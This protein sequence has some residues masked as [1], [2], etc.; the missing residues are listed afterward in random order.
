MAARKKMDLLAAIE[1]IVDKAKGTGLSAEFFRKADRYIR[2]VS[3]VMELTKEQSVMLALFVDNSCDTDI[4]ISSFGEYLGCRTSRLLR[5]MNDIDVLEKRELIRGRHSHDEVT[6]R[7]PVEL[8]EALKRN[9]KY[10]PKDYTGLTCVELFGELANIFDMR[11]NK[12]LRYGDMVKKIDD[13]FCCNSNLEYVQKVKSYGFSERTRMLLILFSHLFVNNSDDNVGWHD[14]EF[15]HDGR[16][17]WI[18]V[19]NRLSSGN[20]PLLE[21]NI[22]ENN[23]DGG[24]GDR[25]SFRMT[26]KAKNELF[27]ELNLTSMNKRSK[28]GDIV[29]YENIVPKA[30]FYNEKNKAQVEELA[31]LLDD[32]KYNQIRS[33]MKDTGFRCAFTCLLY[34]APGTGKTETALQLARQTGRDIM[35][36]NISQIKSMWVGE[37]EKNIK[38]VFDNYRAMVNDSQTTPILLFNEADAIIGKRQEGTL[39]SVDKMEN[40]IQNIILQEMEMLDGI[41]IATTNLAQNM[42]KAFE[43]RFLYKIKFDKPTVEARTSMWREMIPVLNEE[44]SRILAGKFDFSGGQIENIARHYTIGKILHGDSEDVVNTLSTYCESEKLES[45]DKLRIGFW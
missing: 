28:R 36:V 9:E 29:R 41:L 20:H 32:E 2:Y 8:I 5:Y 31:S 27:G 10:V 1:Q 26:N 17:M 12:E 30:L 13:L 23:N 38:Q 7:V 33:R 24:F 34:G 40:S 22:I 16:A 6:Y 18:S 3:E 43:R 4:T 14:L 39:R 37:S 11:E 35:Q 44:E 45:N 42:D 15:M 19:K 21:A 25:N